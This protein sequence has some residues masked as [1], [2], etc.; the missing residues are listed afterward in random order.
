MR[1]QDAIWGRE[2]K[3]NVVVVMT[4]DDLLKLKEYFRELKKSKIAWARNRG[5][6]LPIF[7]PVSIFQWTTRSKLR[8]KINNPEIEASFGEFTRNS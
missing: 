3:I 4:W 1:Q 6:P 2:N 7:L 5:R 8:G